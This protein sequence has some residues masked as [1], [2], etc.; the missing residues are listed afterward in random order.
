MRVFGSWVYRRVLTNLH[1]FV[2]V[3]SKQK[4][5]VLTGQNTIA[6][7]KKSFVLVLVLPKTKTKHKIVQVR[8]L[9]LYPNRNHV[10]YSHWRCYRTVD[11]ACT[12]VAC[13]V[14]LASRTTVA[15]KRTDVPAH[16]KCLHG[17]KRSCT[18]SQPVVARL[19]RALPSKTDA[20]FDWR[21]V[22]ESLK[23]VNVAF[24]KAHL[25]LLDDRSQ[26]LLPMSIQSLAAYSAR[27]WRGSSV[28]K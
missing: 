8:F 1:D 12:H 3:L 13:S 9:M 28:V 15:S 10:P 17:N 25:L 20:I 16:G 4:L 19:Q 27:W 6:K 5:F 23:S 24:V 21:S 7:P 22:S 18:P 14:V 26:V 11:W 2:L